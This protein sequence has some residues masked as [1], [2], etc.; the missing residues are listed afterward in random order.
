M[1]GA[2][3]GEKHEVEREL[4]TCKVDRPIF[5]DRGVT[6]AVLIR[7]NMNATVGTIQER[8]ATLFGRSQR[9]SMNVLQMGEAGR[10]GLVSQTGLTRPQVECAL[11]KLI[12][13]N[14]VVMR[15]GRGGRTTQYLI[16]DEKEWLCRTSNPPS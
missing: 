3:G 7:A 15:G 9:R 5:V 4:N 10:S 2:E 12:K 11:K 16:A 13:Q 8:V 14:K 6:V 1:A